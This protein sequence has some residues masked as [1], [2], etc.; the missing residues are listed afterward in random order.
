M[1][2]NQCSHAVLEVSGRALEQSWV[3][4]VAFD[5]ACVSSIREDLFD[6][7]A[8]A[9]AYRSARMRLLSHL[10]P[11]SLVVLNADDPGSAECLRAVDGPT[12][13]VGIDAAAEIRAAIVEQSLSEQTFL[14]IAGSEATPVRT[15]IVGTAH[16]HHCLTAAAVGLAYGLDLP[17]VARG[18]ESVDYVPGRLE[19]IECGQPFGVFVDA[20]HTPHALAA[21][22]ETLRP[23]VAGRLICVADAG[24]ERNRAARPRLGKVLAQRADVAA[25]TGDDPRSEEPREIDAAVLE[26]GSS[27]AGAKVIL[28]RKRAIRWALAQAEPGDCVVLAGRANGREP[29]DARGRR[30]PAD[31]TLAQRWLQSPRRRN[32]DAAP[33]NAEKPSEP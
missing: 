29:T 11:E 25:I 27:P 7:P 33:T 13:T 32:S 1:V 4:G 12:L 21:L 2:A 8:T 3:A 9:L 24:G 5:A 26:G 6:D 10:E 16:I 22:L 28:D 30:T 20:A 18:L 17:T 14:L 15:R 19:R 23:L 31:R